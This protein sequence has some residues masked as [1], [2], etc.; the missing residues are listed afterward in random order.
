MYSTHTLPGRTVMIAGRERLYFSGTSYLGISKSPDFQQ[1]LLEAMQQ[2]G[3]SYSS[4]RVSNLQ[5]SVYQQAEQLLTSLTGAAS[6]LT[7][8]S[9]YLAGQAA[10]HA[11]NQGQ[12]FVYAPDTH[13]AVWRQAQDDWH[14]DYKTWALGLPA[15][16]AA[17]EGKLVI[18]SNSLNPLQAEKYRFDWVEHLPEDREVTLLVDDSHGFG[19]I[20]KDGTGIY[21]ELSARLKDNVHLV[22]VSSFGK[23]CGIPGGMVLGSQ[24]MVQKLWKSP[25]FTAGSPI[26]PAYLEAFL[27]AQAIYHRA[28]KQLFA[29]I[30]HFRQLVE[31]TH[32]FRYFEHYPVFYTPDNG[33]C[34]AVREDCLLSSFPYPDPDSQPITRV[35]VNSLHQPKDLEM[36]AARIWHYK[37]IRQEAGS[38]KTDV[39]S[40]K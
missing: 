32:L 23:A 2:Y 16:L 26:P 24:A 5:L 13:P 18:V 29:N 6:A 19:I 4:S 39:R 40:K 12:T 7:F 37:E 21:P 27:Q 22:V 11:L 38:P 1:V 10:V 35:V 33:L 28:R 14:G 31:A 8:S 36:L 34:E 20:G 25:F 30:K 17:T 9:G 15:T 3:S